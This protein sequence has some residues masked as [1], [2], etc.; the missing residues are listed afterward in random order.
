MIIAIGIDVDDTFAQFVHHALEAGATLRCINLRVAQRRVAVQ[1]VATGPAR[2]EH[3]GEVLTL[4]PDDAYFLAADRSVCGGN[5]P[6]S[7]SPLA[8]PVH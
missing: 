3:A 2:I 6:D 5:R 1:P 7:R 8:R 4:A